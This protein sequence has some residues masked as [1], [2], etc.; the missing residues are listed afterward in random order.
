MPKHNMAKL[1]IQ[2]LLLICLVV[3]LAVTG[4]SSSTDHDALVAIKSR[5]TSD[6]YG[7]L[8]TNWSSNSD[9]CYWH[10]VYCSRDN[11]RVV[12][13]NLHNM[14][15]RGTLAPQ[16]GNLSSLASLDI[17]QNKFY[18]KIPEELACLCNLKRLYLD[19]NEFNGD[20]LSSFGG[21][22][23]LRDLHLENNNFTGLVLNSIG[24]ISK[25]EVLNISFNFLQGNIPEDIGRLSSLKH[26]SLTNNQLSGSLPLAIFNMSSLQIIELAAN[27]LSDTLQ[28]DICD[29]LPQLER[30]NL[31]QN[32][33]SGKI[34]STIKNCKKLQY[35][36]LAINEFQGSIPREIGNVTTLKSL[37]LG[38][39]QFQGQVPMELGN[40]VN[41]QDLHISNC[42]L[43]AVS[44]TTFNIS[45]LRSIDLTNNKLSG[46]LPE[47]MIDYEHS[48]LKEI[49]LSSN[50]FTGQ[51]PSSIWK[52][53]SLERLSLSYN[54]WIGSLPKEIG[55]L[56]MLKYL[57]LG[58]TNLTGGIPDE[59]GCLTNLKELNLREGRFS[60]PLPGDLFNISTLEIIDLYRNEFCGHLPSSM[61]HWLPNLKSLVLNHNN[62][63]GKIPES[64]KNASKLVT[65]NLSSNSF[66][67]S[68]PNNLGE[69][70]FLERLLLGVNNLTCEKLTPE[71]RFLSSLTN[72]RNLKLVVLA[73]NPLG[74]FLPSSL[75]NFSSSLQLIQAFGSKIIG[76]IP[77][78]IGNLSGLWY[79]GLDDNDLTGPVPRTIGRLHNLEVLYLEQNKL[80][81][82]IPDDICA[83]ENLGD[84]YVSQ[85]GLNGSI[86]ACLGGLK[87]LQRLYLDSN[88]LTSTIPSALWS[89]KDL[90]LLNLSRNFFGGELPSTIGTDFK[91]LTLLDLSY[92]QL[93]G[94]IPR[95]IGGAQQLSS[96]FL[97]NNKF[98]GDIPESVGNL[99][100]LEFLDLS[101]N[102]LSGSIPKSMEKLRYLQ[103]LNVSLNR[104]QGEI[105]SRG[106]FVN[107]TA[108]SFKG[109]RALCGP[110]WLEVPLCRARTANRSQSKFVPLLKYILPF[111][112][113][114]LLIAI[115]I[116]FVLN[117]PARNI[118]PLTTG[119]SMLLE[120]RR[121][122]YIELLRATESFSE[123]NLLGTGGF[124][125]VFRGILSDG[126]I[127]AIKVLN[128][129]HEGAMKS[130]KAE[131]DVLHQIRHRNIVQIISSCTNL[132]FSALVLEYM[133]NGNLEKWLY[134]HNN[135]LDMIQRLNIMI[136]V[137]LAIEYLHHGQVTPMLHCDLKPSNILLDEDMVAHVGDFGLAKILGEEEFMERTV[138]LATVGYMA[139]EYGREGLV[140]AKGDVYSY[141]VVLMETF[142][143]KKPTDEMSLRNWVNAALHG[144][145]YDVVDKNML[146]SD[147]EHLPMKKHCSSSILSLALDCTA[148]YAAERPTMEE[149]IFRLQKIRTLFPR[150]FIQ[151]V[152]M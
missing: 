22:F 54:G 135:Y 28:V 62:F 47:D 107:F 46:S 35:L 26:L 31:S 108:L 57:Y 120:W 76:S 68:V 149:V 106:S 37:Y 42:F 4:S 136:D 7:I 20:I 29:R 66:S 96:L 41:L 72:C 15:L 150:E 117:S 102:K 51:I 146:A 38:Y 85:N 1:N 9:I 92:N 32:H 123:S 151:V 36:S 122:S 65:I 3:C 114:A 49:Y 133:P 34:P 59:I 115:L 58:A 55:N 19:D 78:G 67:G 142:T 16:I 101:D 87:S 56:T 40:L 138:T 6:P 118:R 13:L 44:P 77:I 111:T 139:P 81:G 75:G 43:T 112:A 94:Y 147:D 148:F 10:G 128:L 74:G 88:K 8:A 84:L 143:R 2:V 141:G 30:L 52:V 61:G 80:K 105:P 129:E 95:S 140:S 69:L 93:S 113:L 119:E 86:P 14:G 21:L 33:F 98:G 64:T 90:V 104:L 60:G 48:N 125:S 89:L 131:C 116:I 5:I 71:L 134:S 18:G 79:L 83:L 121:V 130:F 45:S 124:G 50:Q 97:S 24:N 27:K 91:E 103:Y 126:N 152:M 144:S 109:N 82:H 137:G 99:I 39:N 132:D 12:S 11:D 63:S 110:P 73:L 23:D 17:G 53:R 145:I 70:E 100:G 25:L 127:V